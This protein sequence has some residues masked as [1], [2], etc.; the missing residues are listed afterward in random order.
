MYHRGTHFDDRLEEYTGPR[1]S[2]LGRTCN[3]LDGA[4]PSRLEPDTFLLRETAE[5]D[6]VEAPL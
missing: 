5:A 6:H 3:P 1:P 4:D 2:D